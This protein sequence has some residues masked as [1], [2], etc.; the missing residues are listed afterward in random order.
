[1]YDEWVKNGVYSSTEVNPEQDEH[2]IIRDQE[3]GNE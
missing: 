3:K 2:L 1:M